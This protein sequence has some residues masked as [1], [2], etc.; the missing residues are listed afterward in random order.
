M[1]V[2]SFG[3]GIFII[4]NFLSEKECQAHIIESEKIGYTEASMSS[5]DGDQLVKEH[6]NNDR[7][8]Y[9]NARLAEDLYLRAK[10][11]LPPT[12]NSWNLSGFNERFRFYKYQG[13]Q[14]FK[15]HLDGT[16]RRSTSEESFLTFL[17]YL[18]DNFTGG[19]TDFIWERIK[20][21]AGSALVFPH[22]L[23]HQ[24]SVVSDGIKYILRT[25]VMYHEYVK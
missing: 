22:R 18:N 8:V 17:I 6:R 2:E 23:K 16:H 3:A 25:D 14:F 20:P 9:D 13:Q 7:I 1:E 10:P 19:E 15:F 11:H 4:R 5:D 12:L 21:Q 24:G